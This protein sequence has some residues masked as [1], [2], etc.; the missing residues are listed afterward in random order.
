MRHTLTA[1]LTGC[2][3]L[4]SAVEVAAC[5]S[6]VPADRLP[7]E[8]DAQLIDRAQRMRQDELRAS[9]DSVFLAQVSAARL[10]APFEAEFSLMPIAPL[11]DMPLPPA[12]LF[13]RGSLFATCDVQMEL[14]QILVVYADRDENGWRVVQVLEYA[15][16]Q[17]RPPDMPTPRDIAR[18]VFPLP[19]YSD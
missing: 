2:V 9:S 10:V 13:R 18:G 16:L 19:D 14:G 17:D 8:T 15:R 11:Y 3:F 5:V 4:A 7:G 1:L 6:V 12:P